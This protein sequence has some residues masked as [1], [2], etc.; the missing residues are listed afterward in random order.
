MKLSNNLKVL[1]SCISHFSIVVIKCHEQKQLSQDFVLVYSP[2]GSRASIHKGGK[3]MAASG[4]SRKLKVH[5]PN[6][7]NQA[8]PPACPSPNKPLTSDLLCGIIFSWPTSGG[9]LKGTPIFSQFILTLTPNSKQREQTGRPPP[10]V[11]YFL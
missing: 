5:I 3:G 1:S 10:L 6:C 11:T 7:N 9:A 2:R 4:Q 8:F